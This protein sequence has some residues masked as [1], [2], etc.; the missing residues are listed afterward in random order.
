MISNKVISI[1]ELKTQPSKYV[2]LLKTEWDKYI[3][4]HS[5]PKAVLMDVEK[6]EKIISFLEENNLWFSDDEN[7]IKPINEVLG[8]DEKEFIFW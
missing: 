7:I 3:F 2:N 1:S 6:Y 4:V 8:W 5:K